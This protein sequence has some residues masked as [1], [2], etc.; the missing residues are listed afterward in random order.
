MAVNGVFAS[1]EAWPY[2]AWGARE[3]IQVAPSMMMSQQGYTKRSVMHVSSSCW[4]PAT[5]STGM[6]SHSQ[7]LA[8]PE[9]QD[10]Q[11]FGRAAK[12]QRQRENRRLGR[13]QKSLAATPDI[14]VA[15]SADLTETTASLS[16]LASAAHSDAGERDVEDQDV[17]T[18]EVPVE[19]ISP[20]RALL[21]RWDRHNLSVEVVDDQSTEGSLSPLLP[22]AQFGSTP[23]FD[24]FR[25]AYRQFRLGSGCG[26][27]GEV[28]DSPKDSDCHIGPWQQTSFWTSLRGAVGP[29]SA[30]AA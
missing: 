14:D 28:S 26:A 27:K 1:Q 20:T 30:Q 5:S 8:A 25:L 21:P 22:A 24:E 12:R 17:E 19:M 7:P 9:N 18:P 6:T 10:S 16:D 4:C 15:S 29:L 11:L 23:E 13:A 3:F 2:G